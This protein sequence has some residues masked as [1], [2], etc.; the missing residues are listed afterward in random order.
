MPGQARAAGVQDRVPL[1][2]GINDDS[3]PRAEPGPGP[4]AVLHA[5]LR[6]NGCLQRAGRRSRGGQRGGGV[7]G[8]I[9]ARGGAIGDRRQRHRAAGRGGRRRQRSR[10]PSRRGRTARRAGGRDGPRRPGRVP[11]PA[12]DDL[13]RREQRR[14]ARGHRRELRQQPERGHGRRGLRGRDLRHR[15]VGVRPAGDLS[16]LP[17][18]EGQHDRACADRGQRR[19]TGQHQHRLELRVGLLQRATGRRHARHRLHP[20]HLRREREDHREPGPGAARRQRARAHVPRPQRLPVQQRARRD[21]AGR[22]GAGA[23]PDPER[24]VRQQRRHG[25]RGD[26]PVRTGQRLLPAVDACADG[27]GPALRESRVRGIGARAVRSLRTGGHRH[28]L[29]DRNDPDRWPPIGRH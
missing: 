27:H 11:V 4:V 10:H 12:R 26:L 2:Q 3:T 7:R 16:H 17:R 24:R 14:H 15:E 21:D 9:R 20:L 6:G 25:H 29:R 13:R 23:R 28:L 5:F 19:G 22:C 8:C 1:L 18:R